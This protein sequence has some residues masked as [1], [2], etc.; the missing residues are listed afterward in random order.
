MQGFTRRRLIGCGAA[1]L[2]LAAG[3]RASGPRAATAFEITRTDAEWQAMLG[4]QAY[5]VLRKQATEAPFTSPLNEEHRKGTFACAGCAL[6]LF[7]SETKFESGTGWPSFWQPWRTRSP[8]RPTR[9][10]S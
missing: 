9:A 1:A 5:A 7:A 6:P 10:C 4:P 3:A 8:P 2:A